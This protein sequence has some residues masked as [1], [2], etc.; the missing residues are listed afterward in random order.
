MSPSGCQGA[1]RAGNAGDAVDAV[2]AV[3]AAA[4]ATGFSATLSARFSAVLPADRLVDVVLLL[5]PSVSHTAESQHDLLT[6]AAY[7]DLLVI[8]V[9]NARHN[10]RHNPST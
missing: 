10:R 5:V 7:D 9:I 1:A 3:R 8:A 4:A 6:T 2:S